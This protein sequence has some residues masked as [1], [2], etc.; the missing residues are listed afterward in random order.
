MGRTT[1]HK[2]WQSAWLNNQTYNDYFFRL[3]S[4]GIN[5]IEYEG[6]PDTC[7]QRFIERGLW[8]HGAMLFFEDEVMGL[9]CLPFIPGGQIDVY[10]IPILRRAYARNGNYN[11]LRTNKDSVIIY[12]NYSHLADLPTVE[13]FARRIADIQRT[14]DVNIIGQK[15]PKIITGS[16]SQR[17]VMKNLMMQYEGNEPFIFGNK[18]INSDIELN[19]LDTTA[20]YVADKLE[21]QKHMMINEVLTYYGI[22]NSNQ[23]KKERLV[24]DEVSSNYGMVE[25]SRNVAVDSR[26]DCFDQVNKMFGTN[27]TVRFKSD[28]VTTVN[29]PNIGGRNGEIYD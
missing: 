1:K 26:Q 5:R 29:D 7:S 12:N 2:P 22:E 14:I 10:D 21:I 16:E 18:D 25:N 20:P 27:I 19:V 15:T 17:L 13:L 4:I 28:V 24:A 23:D 3:K 9:L 6:L 8:E 11:A